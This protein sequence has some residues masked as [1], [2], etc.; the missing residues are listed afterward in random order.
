MSNEQK[1]KLNKILIK[2]DSDI[3]YQVDVTASNGCKSKGLAIV[4]VKQNPN[5]P[6]AISSPLLG[7]ILVYPNPVKDYLTI[8]STENFNIQLYNIQG[9][10][11]LIKSLYEPLSKLDISHLASG[12]YTLLFEMGSE[13]KKISKIEIIK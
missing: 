7:Q 1:D 5:P 3:I 11:V 10:L 2:P 9:A 4:Y 8:E 12:Q 13:R 6:S